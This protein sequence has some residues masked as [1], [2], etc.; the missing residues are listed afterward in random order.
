MGLSQSLPYGTSPS[1]KSFISFADRRRSPI[2]KYFARRDVP[3]G[4]D[5]GLFKWGC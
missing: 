5:Q 4:F 3:F 1:L 2:D